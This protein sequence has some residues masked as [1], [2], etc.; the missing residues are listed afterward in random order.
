LL[1]NIAGSAVGCGVF[2]LLAHGLVSPHDEENPTLGQFAAHAV[3]LVPAGVII[4]WAQKLV[5]RRRTQ[6]ARSFVPVTMIAMT[7]AFLVGAYGLR[8]PFDF[9]LAYAAIGAS[10]ESALRA[11]EIRRRTKALRGAAA[12]SL[13]FATGSFLG[14]L[15]LT[16]FARTIGFRFGAPGEDVVRHIVTMVLGGFFIGA[17]T[18]LLSAFYVAQ[19]IKAYVFQPVRSLH[20]MLDGLRQGLVRILSRRLPA[21]PRQVPI[22]LHK[23]RTVEK[24]QLPVWPSEIVSEIVP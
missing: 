22:D 10:V 8:P 16:V 12:A 1:A 17:A 5:L 18:G 2:A 21:M 20:N 7:A 24:T 4:A 11:A 13:L 9:L 15:A 23:S 6:L 3:A 19:R 14:M